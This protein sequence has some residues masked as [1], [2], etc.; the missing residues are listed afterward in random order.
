MIY[1]LGERQ[2]EFHGDDWFVAAN[3]SVIGSVILKNNASIWFNAVVRGDNDLITIGEN[4]NVQDGAV[5]H[6]DAGIRL[7]VGRDV[8]IGHLAML[9]G[10]TIGDN[11]LIGI[12]SVILN[13]AVIGR[14]SIVGAG[15]LIGEGKTFPDGVLILGV[16]GRVVRALDDDE[17]ARLRAA[18]AH[19]VDNFKRYKQSLRLRE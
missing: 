9:H 12:R 10:C 3:A 15:T 14:D 11:S 19:Y 17:R 2:V 7:T 5:L 16:P 1:T 4:S 6:T 13:R 18:A 8:T